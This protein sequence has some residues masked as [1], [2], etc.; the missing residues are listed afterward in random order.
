MSLYLGDNLISG[1]ATTVDKSERIGQ[2]IQSILPQT[3][4]G[5]HL[6][7]GALIYGSGIYKDFVDYIAGLY[8]GGNY[9]SVFTTEDLWQSSNAT[10]G[11]CGKFV[12]DS[13]NNTVRLPKITGILEGTTDVSALGNLV[14]AGLPMSW[15]SHTHTRGNMNITGATGGGGVMSYST[16]TLNNGAISVIPDSNIVRVVGDT[17]SAL[18]LNRHLEFDASKNWTGSTSTPNYSDSSHNNSTVQPQT[19]KCYYYIVI[20]T[21]TKTDVQVDIEEIAV[22]LNGKADRDGSN[23]NSSVKN[24]DG[25]W[26]EKYVTFA[27][28]VSFANNSTTRY[29][30]STY[31]PNDNYNYEIAVRASG[32]TGTTAGNQ[33]EASFS[34]DLVTYVWSYPVCSAITRTASSQRTNGCTIIPVG[35]G[36][37]INLYVSNGS[38]GLQYGYFTAAA[39]RRIG[40]NN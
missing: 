25:Q 39:Y 37:Y 18:Y 38:G 8:D 12:Y 23:M 32:S 26:I 35:T 4:A 1:I 16:S 7:D 15:L 13:T 9:P 19:I 20:A 31:L 27:G 11:V 34:S 28:S 5:L 29:D 10:Y 21:S 14:E 33:F 3:D 2:L 22:D 24:F 30:L 17:T 6:L 40:T 36:R